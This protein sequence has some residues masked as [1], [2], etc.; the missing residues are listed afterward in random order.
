MVWAL[1]AAVV[2]L[3]LIAA[4]NLALQKR[5]RQLEAEIAHLRQGQDVS[6][7]VS[8]LVHQ[9]QM[10]EAIAVYRKATGFG[11]AESKRAVEIIAKHN[12][13]V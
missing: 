9:G 7:R 3:I 2:L 4:S 5:T 1:V 12:P 8:Y 10:P 6:E 11:L 13:E